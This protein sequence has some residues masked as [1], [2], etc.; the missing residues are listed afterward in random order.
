MRKKCELVGINRS[1]IYYKEKPQID[2]SAIIKEINEI[3]ER[4]SFYGHRKVLI[5]LKR[6]GY[7]IN[8]KKVQRLMRKLGLYAVYP[9][10]TTTIRNTSHKVFPYLLR[11]VF[12]ERPNQAWGI[13]LTYI[14]LNG[15]WV[16][17]VAII[18]FFSRKIMG[19][20]ISTIADVKMCLEA[21]EMAL[22][23]ATPE[24]MNSDQGCQFT[25]NEW[26]QMVIS[27]GIKVSMDGVGRWADN[28]F[29]E[30][31]W[32][33]LKYEEIFLSSIES[34]NQLRENV[35]VYIGF[36]N[37]DRPHQTLDYQTPNAIYYNFLK[38]Y[39][40]LDKLSNNYFD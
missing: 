11:N 36:Y 23:K 37:S 16:Y 5:C 6:K 12:I 18:D 40:F 13:D 32:R 33:S 21:L 14:K 34:M 19:W 2:N 20:A 35:S 7:V 38:G 25:S 8:R 15:H 26:V 22:K 1:T 9:K 29:I 3:Y 27:H 39:C 24:I 17:C 10:K 30:R 28:V 31:F 4:H